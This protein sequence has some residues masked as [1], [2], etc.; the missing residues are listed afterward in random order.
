MS[1]F[2]DVKNFMDAMGQDHPDSPVAEYRLN[3]GMKLYENLIQEEYLEFCGECDL[4][5]KA[6]GAID[7][8]WVCI[9][10]LHSAGINPQP[11]WDAVRAA[12]M[13]KSTGPICEKTG[14]RLKPPGFKH[15]DIAALIQAQREVKTCE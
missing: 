12:N 10:Y 4:R 2:V 8:I 15:P 14:K 1:V 11:L 5:G 9:G 13:T 7:L 3:A 6:D